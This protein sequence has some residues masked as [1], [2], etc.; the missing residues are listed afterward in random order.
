MNGDT[1]DTAW[2]LVPFDGAVG[3]ARARVVATLQ[4]WGFHLGAGQDDVALLVSELVTNALLHGRGE[5]I[6]IGLYASRTEQSVTL[7]VLDASED[8][9]T[10][11]LS[12]SED[13]HGRGMF[14]VDALT[15]GRW[16][17][18]R[19]E[20]GKRVL[21]TLPLPPAPHDERHRHVLDCRIQAARPQP[22]VVEAAS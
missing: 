17:T 21:A 5:M 3:V 13:E 4:L 7:D 18:Q 14:I 10:V 20:H 16:T 11:A 1:F 15:Q 8:L 19:T 6:T 9:P 2:P 12:G 22:C